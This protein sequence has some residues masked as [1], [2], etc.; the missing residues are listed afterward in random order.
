MKNLHL[1][2]NIIPSMNENFKIID[3]INNLLD[4][5]N[6]DFIRHFLFLEKLKNKNEK[7]YFTPCKTENVMLFLNI[8]KLKKYIDKDITS[9]IDFFND[10]NIDYT[11]LIPKKIKWMIHK[12]MPNSILL[13]DCCDYDILLSVLN[14]NIYINVNLISLNDE[15]NNYINIDINTRSKTKTQ[16]QSNN[17]MPKID[18]YYYMLFIC[19]K[20]N[21][22]LTCFNF[23]NV[24]IKN[25]QFDSFVGSEHKNI[26]IKNFIDQLY[27]NVKLY[28]SKKR[29]EL[30]LNK[31]IINKSCST[32]LF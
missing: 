14:Y 5:I 13:D 25:M 15:K 26:L 7:K 17:K 23:N 3:Y 29:L 9:N 19:H 30:R 27:G 11:F 2:I 20:K 1:V 10:A 4:E 8:N 28:K 18:K 21:I 16:M 12:S 32:K 31:E 6:V 22:Y 24:N